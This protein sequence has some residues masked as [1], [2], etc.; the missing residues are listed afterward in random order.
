MKYRQHDPKSVYENL[1]ITQLKAI[2]EAME[3]DIKYL[4]DQDKEASMP[5]FTNRLAIIEDVIEYKRI[6]NL[7]RR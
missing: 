4:E 1:N 7:T 3:V 5:F 2:K 6:K